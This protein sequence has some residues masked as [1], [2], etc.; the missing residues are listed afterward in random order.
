MF[1]NNYV[2]PTFIPRFTELFK[3]VLTRQLIQ[4]HQKP[5]E[6]RRKFSLNPWGGRGARESGV[7]V[8]DTRGPG[9]RLHPNIRPGRGGT[10]RR[11]RRSTYATIENGNDIATHTAPDSRNGPKVSAVV[12]VVVVLSS[13]G[14]AG[15]RYVCLATRKPSGFA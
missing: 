7:R 8:D 9:P 4:P 10:G 1:H 6:K 15:H 11:G 5:S 12:V 2:L 13:V 3:P 14:H